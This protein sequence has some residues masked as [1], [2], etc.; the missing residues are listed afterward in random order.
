MKNL[1]LSKFSLI[2]AA[3]F[4]STMAP[5]QSYVFSP[6]GATGRF[7][8][9]QAQVNVGYNGGPLDG[10]VSINTQGIQEW[11]VPLSGKYQI[12]TDGARGGKGA[13]DYGFG[14]RISAEYQLTAGQKL[15]IVV[16][17]HGDDHNTEGGGGGGASYVWDSNGLIQ[18]AGGGGGA[19]DNTSAPFA[20]Y[21]HGQSTST[22]V[23]NSHPGSG[24]AQG[25]S[26]R[27]YGGG[28]GGWLSDGEPVPA[29]EF[30]EGGHRPAN[31][32]IGGKPYSDAYS[33][34]GFGGGGGAG[35]DA[36]GGG[37]GYTGGQG[38]SYS[39]SGPNAGGG[40]SY[41]SSSNNVLAT[42]AANNGDGLVVITLLCTPM[43]IERS[44]A[45]ELCPGTLL[46]LSATSP[47]GGIVSW[48]NGVRNGVPFE[49]ATTTTFT[50]V[51][52][53]PNDCPSSITIRVVDTGS[54]VPD[55][56]TLP[57]LSAEC[58]IS[59]PPVPTATDD[60]SGSI[61][62]TTTSRFPMNTQGR[63][64]ITW[65][66]DDGNGNISTQTQALVINDV[67]PPL[68]DLASLPDLT[69]ECAVGRPEPPTATD[70]CIGSI[71]GTTD[72]LFP[73]TGEG[74]D[75]ITWS[76]D[77]GHGNRSTQTQI[78]IVDDV[79][80]PV[81]LVNKLP[82]ITD[83]CSITSVTPPRAIDN[84]TDTITATT[85]QSF[86]VNKQGTTVITWTFD[87]GNGNTISQNQNLI[88]S[89]TEA[90]VPD[91]LSL[92]DIIAE[93]SVASPEI[94]TATDNCSGQIKGVP[95]VSFPLN[96]QDTTIVSWSFDDGHGNISTQTQRII[97]NDQT[98]PV[99]NLASLPDLRD[100]CSVEVTMP[101]TA[102]D[103]CLGEIE[104]VA[105]V[106]FPI[107]TQGRTIVTW[108]YD[109]GRGNRTTQ[110]QNVYIEDL[111]A[112]VPDK[113]SLEP[114]VAECSIT[115]A[116]PTATDNCSGSITATTSDPVV[117]SEPGS[118]ALSWT[119][120][121]G[122]GN[123]STQTQTVTIT[124]SKAPVPDVASLP[125]INEE[126][127][128][129]LTPPTARDEC[130]GTIRA[131]TEDSL[132]YTVQG[133]YTVTWVYDD[134][135]GNT[136]SQTQTVN[137][138]DV[139]APVPD[140][141]SLE[142][143]VGECNLILTPPTATDN[144]KGSLTGSTEDP[145]VYT[146]QG[147]YTLTWTYDD[148]NGNTSSQTQHVIVEDLTAPTATCPENVITCDGRVTDIGLRDVHDACGTPVVTYVLSG[149]T[150]GTGIGDASNVLFEA[151]V[152]TVNYTVDDGYGN[153]M[154]C[155]V[156][157]SYDQPEP[158]AIHQSGDTLSTDLTGT[159]QWYDCDHG[160]PISGATD[161]VL[162]TGTNG[163]F[164]LILTQG[165]CTDTSDCVS[166]SGVG[167][168]RSMSGNLDIKVYPNP[169]HDWITLDLG[170][171]YRDIR[172]MIY[173]VNGQA[174][175]LLEFR[176]SA[177]L[178]LDMSKLNRGLYL[179]KVSTEA[180][181]KILRIAKE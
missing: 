121:D 171:E 143:A 111:T 38:G 44:P 23:Y 24:G 133:S 6:C 76:F 89:D 45:S 116:A 3:L 87:D 113:A 79:S 99:P 165:S 71:A 13:T 168:D 90:P 140:E 43:N 112:P 148:G 31:G 102:K 55:L 108:T 78:I 16:G 135:H 5:A 174:L 64:I 67:S 32:S 46:T 29:G 84:C 177:K 70:A 86:P 149:A 81:P 47:G 42:A 179:L 109:D 152:T 92:P 20:E 147:S 72:A 97:L 28:G 134:G 164:A 82:D 161:R 128:V 18:A 144:C 98:A 176:E 10:Q 26:E 25:E 58:S 11:I 150:S 1:N 69:G 62:G 167:I 157:V 8:P 51:S 40:G 95:D 127:S 125:E 126:C 80:D 19:S 178:E 15:Y 117:Y 131:T 59:E 138:R 61:Q 66:Y 146:E 105:N 118:Y 142:D 124:D 22:L 107:T 4:L 93:C 41:W 52:T 145:V 114:L 130:V 115:L 162:V 155:T 136:S 170:H 175:E 17:Q 83:A 120:D 60:C 54:P 96:V 88:I 77:D 75:T 137:I 56:D 37:G 104:G 180:G 172:L 123:T 39:K 74:R 50:A 34:G 2:A 94:P 103:D 57:V 169:A 73:F 110:T 21:M 33:G 173:S 36:G 68:P 122:N 49:I 9:T 151:G 156:E 14:A 181:N 100:E 141:T 119:Y 27:W 91:A 53:D 153:R 139:T 65:T 154:N 129:T 166:V 159:Y 12:R 7:G 63:H 106:E 158:V 101:P 35:Y 132:S 30:G 48:D 160:A 163:N 85:E